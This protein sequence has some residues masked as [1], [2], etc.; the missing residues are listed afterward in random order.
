MS[1]TVLVTGGNRG[2]GLAIARRFAA[3][4]DRVTVT[5]R[6]GEPV[7]G[8]AV[9]PCDVRDEAS[10]EDAFAKLEAADGPADVVVSNAGIVSDQVLLLMRE[11]QF[12]EVVDTNLLGAY[13][14]ARR[15]VRGML[16]RR[17]GRLIFI[18]SVVGL[19]GSPGQANYA[20]A[21]AGLVGLARSLA[22]ELG[23]RGITA[24]VVAPGFVE[25]AMTAPL[26][27]KRKDALIAATPLGRPAS[28]EEIAGVV[29]FLAGDAASYITGAVIPVD[30]G[31]GMGH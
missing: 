1:R 21:K 13:R 7:E 9:V 23:P 31:F 27:Q 5:S 25:T 12:A 20:S 29:A 18:S 26:P 22:R 17:R 3:D 6:S 11:Q 2:I 8:L 4:G 16:A 30:G 14:V 10:V 15:A 19:A 24:N 28:P